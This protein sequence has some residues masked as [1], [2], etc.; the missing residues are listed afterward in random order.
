MTPEA[1]ERI[2]TAKI[3]LHGL[4]HLF[5]KEFAN[6]RRFDKVISSQ[7]MLTDQDCNFIM[8]STEIEKLENCAHRIDAIN[9]NLVRFAHNWNN[10]TM[11]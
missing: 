5:D 3:S 1:I 8:V 7:K 10:G 11:E 9:K 2:Q 4:E 6:A